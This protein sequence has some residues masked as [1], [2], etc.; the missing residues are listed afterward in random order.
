[1]SFNI[2]EGNC[3]KSHMDQSGFNLFT[4]SKNQRLVSMK[5]FDN[6]AALRARRINTRKTGSELSAN[7]VISQFA[8]S[9]MYL[10]L[11]G[12]TVGVLIY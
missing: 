6:S 2:N 10:H 12:I 11:C 1:M 8:N 3:K 7:V 4:L 9:D 5:R